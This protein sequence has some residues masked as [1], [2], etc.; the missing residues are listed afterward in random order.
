MC[1]SVSMRDVL[2]ASMVT[3]QSSGPTRSLRCEKAVANEAPGPRFSPWE[4]SVTSR[5]SPS[6]RTAE[7]VPSV[8]PSSTT[9]ILQENSPETRSP[10]ERRSLRSLSIFSSSLRTGRT[11][12]RFAVTLPLPP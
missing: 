7:T 5:P 6:R 3:T 1:S 11:I 2:S 9:I 10:K 4:R 12:Y 8:L